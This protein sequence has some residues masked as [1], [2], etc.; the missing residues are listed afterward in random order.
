MDA[1]FDECVKGNDNM[2]GSRK[3]KLSKRYSSLEHVP[4]RRGILGFDRLGF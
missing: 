1:V 3:H 2:A 4:S